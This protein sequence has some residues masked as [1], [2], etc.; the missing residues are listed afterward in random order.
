NGPYD[1][2]FYLYGVASGGAAEAGPYNVSGVQVNNGLFLVNLDFGLKFDGNRRWIEVGVRPA[3]GGA[4]TTL[5]PRQEVT[6]SPYA[7][8]SQNA[9]AANLASN[10]STA[11]TAHSVDNN[12]VTTSKL[13]D[14]AVTPAKLSADGL[15]PN[16][17]LKFNGSQWSYDS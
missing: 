15:L 14:G 5:S 3:G 16:Q 8:Y 13:A 2:S 7:L 1:F 12:S 6:A 10:A 4:Y 17:I 9:G 11:N